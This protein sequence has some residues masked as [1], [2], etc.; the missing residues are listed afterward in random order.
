MTFL[1]TIV[2]VVGTVVLILAMIAAIKKLVVASKE[3]GNW[4]KRLKSVK[5]AL[6]GSGAILLIMACVIAGAVIFFWGI[7]SDSPWKNPSVLSTVDLAKNRWFWVLVFAG[8]VAILIAVIAPSVLSM[9]YGSA[10]AT[11]PSGLS[12]PVC[13]T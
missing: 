10:W 4:D 6:K 8:I 7:L 9:I 5:E 2:S 11:T 12:T 1:W 13:N 3:D